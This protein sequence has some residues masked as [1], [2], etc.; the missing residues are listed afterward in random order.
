MQISIIAAFGKNKELGLNNKLLWSLPDDLKR[1]KELTT[2][3]IIIMGQ[4]TYESIGRPL[5]NRKNFIISRD[6]S[7]QVDGC[8]VVNSLEEAFEK[9]E[10]EKQS[11]RSDLGANKDEIFVIGG[12]EIYKLFLPYA[13][14][15]YL[16]EVEA[17]LPADT[18]FPE[19]NLTEWKLLSEEFHPKD[20]K[21][22]YSFC[23]RKYVRNVKIE[24]NLGIEVVG[25]T[26]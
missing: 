22:K 24:S 6:T 16:T 15:L 20:E 9:F 23:F 25:K 7:Y 14:N 17:E 2:G 18:F 26:T 8:T 10:K 5:L 11:P 19:F 4:K 12:G 21:H 13:N 1:F 3:H